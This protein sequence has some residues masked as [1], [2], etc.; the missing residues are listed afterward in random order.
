MFNFLI[1]NTNGFVHQLGELKVPQLRL[2]YPKLLGY[3][4]LPCMHFLE[5]FIKP[6]HFLEPGNGNPI[7]FVA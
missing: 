2:P 6:M 1:F 5:D 3:F 7:W 4:V